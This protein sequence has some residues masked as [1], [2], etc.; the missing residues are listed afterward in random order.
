MDMENTYVKME[1]NIKES[2]KM[3]FKSKKAK[4]DKEKKNGLMDLNTQDLIKM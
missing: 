1:L 2:G 4:K 3:M